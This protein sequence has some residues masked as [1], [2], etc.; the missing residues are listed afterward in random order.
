[1]IAFEVALKSVLLALALLLF[2]AAAARAECAA[3]A[4]QTDTIGDVK[5]K[6][7]CVTRE[8]ADLRAQNAQLRAANAKSPRRAKST[9]PKQQQS[10]H[11]QLVKRAV[12]LGLPGKWCSAPGHVVYTFTLVDGDIYEGGLLQRVLNI[13]SHQIN[14][15]G[16]WIT[17]L[18]DSITDV[19]PQTSRS[20]VRCAQQ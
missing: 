3:T 14:F 15:D 7:A 5:S 10:S 2:G 13:E 16:R 1:L 17:V 11:D 4:A 9:A 8:N 18:G 19:T 12:E 6:L 20:L